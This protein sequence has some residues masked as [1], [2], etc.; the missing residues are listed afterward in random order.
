MK[1][2]RELLAEKGH[3]IWSV[4]PATTVYDA[5]KLMP[6]KD[7]GAVVVLEGNRL[8][9]IFTERDYARK[10]ILKGQSSMRAHVEVTLSPDVISVQPDQSV[11]ECMALMMNKHIRHLPVLDGEQVVGMISIR[12]ILK[13][14]I[15]VKET[16]KK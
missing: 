5:I 2:V 6:Y 7:I 13:A 14:I 3:E 4:T 8:V 16:P 15:S 11:E 1:L 10:L 12:D 9:G